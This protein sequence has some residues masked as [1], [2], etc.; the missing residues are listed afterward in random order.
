MRDFARVWK[1][2]ERPPVGHGERTHKIVSL[3]LHPDDF[4]VVAESNV[5]DKATLPQVRQNGFEGLLWGAQVFV[6]PYSES[7]Y[8]AKGYAWVATQAVK[9]GTYDPMAGANVE[10][11]AYPLN[12]EEPSRERRTSWERVLLDDPLEREHE[13]PVRFKHDEPLTSGA[14]RCRICGR[15]V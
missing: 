4:A 7:R 10:A 2:A 14:Y 8:R 5:F 11:R 15:D 9:V 13:C 12:L 6:D 1:L 3:Y